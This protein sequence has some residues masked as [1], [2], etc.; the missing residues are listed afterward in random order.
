MRSYSTDKNIDSIIVLY[1]NRGNVMETMASISIPA[2]LKRL[3]EELGY[4]KKFITDNILPEWW[5]KNMSKDPEAKFYAL[6]AI[7]RFF[8]TNISQLL[9]DERLNINLQTRYNLKVN[10]NNFNSDMDKVIAFSG[11]VA[12]Y[13][14]NYASLKPFV[15]PQSPIDLRRMIL[16]KNKFVKLEGILEYC[17]ESG[18]PVI[19]IEN[20][21]QGFRHFDG[22]AIEINNR[23]FI[24][25]SR[26][27]KSPAKLTFN[28]AHELGHIYHNHEGI[29]DWKVAYDNEDAKEIEATQYAL[30]LITGEPDYKPRYSITTATIASMI[31][32]DHLINPAFLLLNYAFHTNTWKFLA[33]HI[34]FLEKNI[35]ATDIIFDYF[36]KYIDLEDINSNSP[37]FL[38]IIKTNAHST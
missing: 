4:K 24:I 35:N 20:I 12:E 5:N 10:K 14:D 9:N 2:V 11:R 17:W 15:H 36:K 38:R 8:K 32:A 19:H 22:L 27:I 31:G 29:P 26:N 37:D 1:K 18:I 7:S 28:I 13:I 34:K 21:P 33:K 30:E 6:S 23:H 25:V 16:R 3:D